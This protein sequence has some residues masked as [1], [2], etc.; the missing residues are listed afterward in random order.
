MET[1]ALPC[2]LDALG[3]AQQFA[4]YGRT[5]SLNDPEFQHALA[6]AHQTGDRP[7]CL[8]TPAG[9]D[10]YVARHQRYRVKRLPDSGPQHHP[11]C[12]SY[13][14]DGACSGLGPLV[15]D[16]VRDAG[17]DRVELRVDFPWV[18]LQ[19]RAVPPGPPGERGEVANPRARMSLRAV[20]HYL[21]ERAG[22]NRWTP[23]MA[24]KRHQGVLHKY[25]MEVAA[26]IAVKGVPLA[27]RLYVPERFDERRMAEVAVRRS[28]KLAITHPQ[29]GCAPMALMVGDFKCCEPG[30]LARRLWI[31]HMPDL[32]LLLAPQG[33]QRLVRVHR[34][35]LEAHDADGGRRLRLV[36][37]ALVRAHRSLG[38]EI[39]TACLMLTSRDWIPLE[40]LS[41]LTLVEALVAQ[42][43]R[44]FKPLRYDAP[45]AA[46]FANALL[47]D[48]GPRP[49]AL[50][51]L[52]AFMPAPDRVAKE[53]L[54]QADTGSAWVWS[55]EQSM[56]QFPL[57]AALR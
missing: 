30:D 8:C 17:S 16:A 2:D 18:R 5:W 49:V 51:L 21:F 36:V 37:A 43:R 14:P 15:G 35:L 9:L 55:V 24:G 46:L 40:G 20:L 57:P 38:F 6:R 19:G 54:V 28:E 4:L 29:D 22:F 11:T 7:R 47:L 33:W 39:D 1:T 41:E 44:F 48:A 50:H 42:Q 13:E 27:D 10:M 3:D 56:P 52:S 45:T 23:A 25:L 32:P 26:G 34:P 12:P 53:H 31:R